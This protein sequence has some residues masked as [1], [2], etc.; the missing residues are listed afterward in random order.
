MNYTVSFVVDATNQALHVEDDVVTFDLNGRLYSVTAPT[1]MVIGNQPGGLPGSLTVIDGTISGTTNFDVGAA[2]NTSGSL[3]I[4]AG[5]LISGSA[6]LNI[7][8][9]GTGTLTVQA[10]GDVSTTGSTTVGT[11]T[12]ISGNATI[13]G[14]GVAA[15]ASLVTGAL[16]VGSTGNGT[17]NVQVGGLLQNSGAAVVGAGSLFTGAGTGIVNVMH[18]DSTWNSLG[19][20]EIGDGGSGEVNVTQW[21]HSD[22]CGRHHRRGSS[23]ASAK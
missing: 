19:L 13:I 21:R 14:N 15:S 23:A 20:L 22:G 11:G 18:A 12:G 7:G 10:D 17:V 9:L 5:G 3:T 4:G 6:N 16:N 1:G 2:A 8:K